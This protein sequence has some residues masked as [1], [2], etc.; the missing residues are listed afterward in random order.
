MCAGL[1]ATSDGHNALAVGCGSLGASSRTK[2]GNHRTASPQTC[3]SADLSSSLGRSSND[4]GD[5]DGVLV[6]WTEAHGGGSD[7]NRF[8][9]SHR[10]ADGG[11]AL[12]AHS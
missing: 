9:V 3:P 7:G 6:R 8:V 1:P 12:G 11:V 2:K 10:I 5:G 4:A